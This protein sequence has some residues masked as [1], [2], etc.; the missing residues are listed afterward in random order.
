MGYINV[1]SGGGQLLVDAEPG[2]LLYAA[3]TIPVLLVVLGGYILWEWYSKRNLA[4]V[5]SPV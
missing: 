1:A 3:I 2:L 5:R 4:V